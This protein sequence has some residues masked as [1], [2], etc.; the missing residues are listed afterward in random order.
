[1]ASAIFH[2][3]APISVRAAAGCGTFLVCVIWVWLFGGAAVSISQAEQVTLGVSRFPDD[4]DLLGSEHEAAWL[5]RQAVGE[6]LMRRHNP[7]GPA[8]PPYR[9][10]SS[11]SVR[12]NQDA[13]SW[14]FRLKPGVVFAN[15]REVGLSDLSFSLER[16]QKVGALTGVKEVEY[17]RVRSGFDRI[18]LGVDMQ[19]TRSNPEFPMQLGGCPILDGQAG[20]VFGEDFGRRTNVVATGRYEIIDYHAG[21]Q[22][23]LRLTPVA[24]SQGGRGPEEIVLRGFEEEKAGLTALRVG[25][26]SSFF[27]SSPEIFSK[28]ES[29]ETL[30]LMECEGRP[31]VRRKSFHFGC[32]SNLNVSEFK[33]E[34]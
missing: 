9:L 21:R 14:S 17:R 13:S 18:S 8:D 29:D 6:G 19:L 31:L 5:V 30:A 34:M 23:V 20:R 1:M 24:R 2:K 10:G 12:S 33:T 27:T 16:C 25:T 7:E 15:G 4:L 11:E 26:I 32:K 22:I 28:A 3:L